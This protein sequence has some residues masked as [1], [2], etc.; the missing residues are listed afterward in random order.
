MKIFLSTWNLMK[1]MLGLKDL[2]MKP[3]QV[4]KFIFLMKMQLCT[5]SYAFVI[6]FHPSLNIE[7][8][9]VVRRFNHTFEQLND[10]SYLKDEMLPFTGPIA[11][12]QL[13]NC[14]AAVFTKKQKY[15][16]SEMFSCELKFVID[17]LKKWLAEKYFG[18]YKEVDMLTKQKFKKQNPINWETTNCVICGFW[19]P[20]HYCLEFSE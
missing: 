1:N 10:V 19:F 3:Q 5:V 13:R 17:L 15:S 12:M 18:R 8:I 7:K 2:K 6:A 4:K 11:T 16:Q 14:T 20:P 9:F